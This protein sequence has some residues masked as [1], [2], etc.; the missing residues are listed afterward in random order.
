MTSPY[1]VP[2]HGRVDRAALL[3]RHSPHVT[4]I[5]PRSPLQVGNGEL[6]FTADVTG[7]QTL[8]DAYPVTDEQGRPV[9]TLLGTMAQWGWHSIPFD[10]QPGVPPGTPDP[11]IEAALRTYDSPRGAVPYV[12]LSAV[13]WGTTT[14]ASATAAS[15]AEE[16]L[17]GNPHRIDLGR[18][19][20]WLAGGVT[21]GGVTAGGVTAGGDLTGGDVA[22]VDQRLDLGRGVLTSRFTVRGTRFEVTTAVHPERD[23][24]AVRVRRTGGPTVP[25][26]IELAFPY[27]SAS[28]GGAQD[29]DR[30]G[31]HTTT[32]TATDGG[33][34]VGR[35]L[36]ATRYTAAIRTDGVHSGGLHSGGGPGATPAPHRV[37]IV[38]RGEALSAVIAFAHGSGVG[39][40]SDVGSSVGGSD[41]GGSDVG[42]SGVVPAD[43]VDD[44]V[45]AA[46]RWWTRFWADGAAVSF[47]AVS[48]DGT[49]DPRAAEL[50][51]RVV[52]SQYL[53]AINGAGSTPPAETGLMLNSWRGRF[54]L[55][56]TWW[57]TAAFP[58]WGRP[59]LLE[60]TL[61]WY[62]T[63][64]GPAR[65]TAARQGFAGARWPK[66]TD[67]SGTETPSSIGPFLVWQQPHPVYLAELSYRARPTAR[68]L[69]RWAP[70]VRETADFMASFAWR[71]DD[72]FHLP[73]PLVPAQ[74]AYA[75]A[76]ATTADPTFELAYWAWALGAAVTW[77]ERLGEHVPQR[78]RDVAVGM[79]RPQPHDGVYPA[80]AGEPWTVRTDHPSMLAA[81][82]VV[83]ATGLVDAEVMGATLDDVVRDWDWESTWGWD[84]AMGAMTAARLGRA[85]AAVDWLLA[86]HGKN[87]FLPNGHNYQTSALPVYLPGNGGLLIAVALMAGGWDGA[88]DVPAP[89]FP[90]SWR[91][92][93]EGFTRLP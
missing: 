87:E 33:Y 21:A 91:V 2:A 82:G 53:T 45:R 1:A 42:S 8:P 46:A 60:R 47:E 76:R 12:D 79:R 5:D 83:P 65:A 17:R 62:G 3:A 30:P 37:R 63:I 67:P 11:T 80:V 36:D 43:G 81:L 26:G 56:M 40:G 15:A 68:T 73:A 34:V 58:L 66:Q 16:W 88:P 59:H 18:V 52:L 39:S 64:L 84:Y 14:G 25:F 69:H 4:G 35:V 10:A 86:Q 28:W 44:V 31:A 85:E 72:G 29:W 71:D 55:E 78:W 41:V 27:G 13:Q 57:H 7:L 93:A 9:G 20:L 74:E 77:F 24:L 19:G 51:R 32:V 22:D 70:I 89:G 48:A 6:A 54:H 61:A 50:E 90:T 75:P 38:A 23:E 49:A 92:V